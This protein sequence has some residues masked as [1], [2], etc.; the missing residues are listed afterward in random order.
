[1]ET[2]GPRVVPFL[3]WETVVVELETGCVSRSTTTVDCVMAKE[4]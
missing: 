4:G 2:R 1:V 3:A